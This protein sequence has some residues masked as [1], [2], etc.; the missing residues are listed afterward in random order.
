MNLNMLISGK[1][2]ER[3][4][5]STLT[6]YHVGGPAKYVVY[7]KNIQELIRLITFIK[8]R[9][10]RFFILGNG[11]NIIAPDKGFKGIV[12]SMKELDEITSSKKSVICE[13]GVDLNKLILYCIRHHMSGLENLSGIPGTVGGALRMNAGAYNTE[14]SD[15]LVYVEVM[16]Y[17][18]RISRI[19]KKNIQFSYRE[20]K[21]L[22]N[23]IILSAKFKFS[24]G[25]TSVLMRTRKRIMRS[26]RKKQP[27]DKHSAGSVFKRP[28]GNFAGRLIRQA[29]LRGYRIGGAEVSKKH[30]GFIITRGKAKA[31]D[32]IALIKLIQRRVYK[33]CNINLKLE[34]II[35]KS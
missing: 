14:I 4:K 26:R 11:T 15:R 22:L 7:P 1:V 19:I 35:I 6:S 27:W 3:V 23:K 2:H 21:K 10:S 24:A 12:I 25:Q 20:A 32:I 31:A 33:K 8:S 18:G 29:G 30:A 16:D 34:Q 17:H 13:A 9:R 5:L 28:S